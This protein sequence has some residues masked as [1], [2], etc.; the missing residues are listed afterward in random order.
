MAKTEPGHAGIRLLKRVTSPLTWWRALLRQRCLNLG[1]GAWFEPGWETVDYCAPE[2]YVD[3]RIRF[4]AKKKL[5]L[6]KACARLI[7]SSHVLEHFPDDLCLAILQEC[8][9]ILSPSG[10]LR[11]SVPDL[12]KAL[13]AYRRGNES[14]FNPENGVPC[15]GESLEAKLLSFFASFRKP[16]YCGIAGY[17]GGPIISKLEVQQK[18]RSLC[19][20]DFVR[21][22]V[23]LIPDDCEHRSHV[24]G[25]DFPK[26]KGLLEQA[27]FK[28]IV[29]SG[30]KRSCIPELQ[31]D[32]FDNRPR[33]SLFVEAVK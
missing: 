8:Y 13:Q 7:F 32:A 27:G 5:P 12:A 29:H 33:V 28:Y 24:N 3:H 26:M 18:F 30:Y 6:P 19:S 31:Q 16:N 11:I 9:R 4:R 17:A 23:S 1:A 25:Y 20:Y 21:W 22:C 2:A 15:T 14:F 10:V